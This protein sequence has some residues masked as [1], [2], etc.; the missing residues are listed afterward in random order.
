MRVVAFSLAVA[1]LGACVAVEPKR[2]DN[3]TKPAPP[4]P[5]RTVYTEAPDP[6]PLANSAIPRGQCGMILWSQMGS[7]TVPIFRSVGITQASMTLENEPVNLVLA[8][9]SGMLRLG[10]GDSQDFITGASNSG[11]VGAKLRFD[12]GQPFP[13]GSYVQRGTLTVSGADGWERVMPVA[14]IAGCKS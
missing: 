5:V 1:V 12:W 8:Q 4:A 10:M 2:S 7:Q 6:S 3:S 13:G 11:A 14:G 9:Q